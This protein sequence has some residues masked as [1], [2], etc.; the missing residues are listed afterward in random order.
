M[1]GIAGVCKTCGFIFD[2]TSLLDCPVCRAARVAKAFSPIDP[3]R[4]ALSIGGK[5]PRTA[6]DWKTM[7]DELAWG[8]LRGKRLIRVQDETDTLAEELSEVP[9]GCSLPRDEADEVYE[10]KR[11]FRL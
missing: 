11:I 10:L 6:E 9:E 8:Y 4:T 5:R 1:S 7:R 2:I 3:L